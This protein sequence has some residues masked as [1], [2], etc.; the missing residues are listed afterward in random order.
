MSI[1]GVEAIM[2]KLGS[3]KRAID[4]GVFVNAVEEWARIEFVPRAQALAPFAT[5]QLRNS[6]TFETTG[7]QVF[8]FAGAA[9]ASH[10]EF[11]TFKM[12]ARPF[13]RPAYQ[14]ARP[15]LSRYTRRKLREVLR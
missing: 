1:T 4:T 6:I 13:I 5:G 11:G 15:L 12:A 2:R 8:V 3:V 14:A 9:H 7:T 10:V